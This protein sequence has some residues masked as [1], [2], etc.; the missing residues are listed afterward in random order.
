MQEMPQFGEMPESMRN[1]MKASIDQARKAFETFIS[2]SQQAMQNFDAPS[3]PATDGL[4]QLNEKIAEFTRLNAD[5]NFS[6][7]L[8]LA[9]AKQL[10]EV[11]EM[12]NAH[13]RELMETYAKQ[14][15]ELRAL[16]SRVVQESAK[17]VQ[18]SM[19]NVSGN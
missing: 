5:A 8:K 2:A 10:N 17:S 18:A 6:F 14:I 4:K 16:T 15:E 7:A 19:P 13:V 3:N 11:I 9:D 12:Q 1:I